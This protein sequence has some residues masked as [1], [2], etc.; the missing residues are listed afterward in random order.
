[1]YGGACSIGAAVPVLVQVQLYCT[2]VPYR[3]YSTVRSTSTVRYDDWYSCTVRYSCT[4]AVCS[5]R[6]NHRYSTGTCRIH[7]HCMNVLVD[8]TSI[9]SVQYWI[10]V[11]FCKTSG[12]W[13]PVRNALLEL[14][15]LCAHFPHAVVKL[16][17]AR[18]PELWRL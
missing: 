7:W 12:N 11:L 3:A 13:L 10:S 15:R 2:T 18:M 4:C 14:Y 8:S 5:A 6:R 9:H 16:L 17:R 1:M